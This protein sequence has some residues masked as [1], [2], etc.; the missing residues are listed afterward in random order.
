MIK[1]YLNCLK[2]DGSTIDGDEVYASWGGTYRCYN[3][4]RPVITLDS[5]IQLNK[6][7][8]E[9]EITYWNIQ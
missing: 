7:K 3:R 9:N 6:E 8:T 4:L 1:L 5:S 2:V